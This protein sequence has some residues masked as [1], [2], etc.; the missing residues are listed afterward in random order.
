MIVDQFL[1]QSMIDEVYIITGT[2]GV[3]G[4]QN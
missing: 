2:P 1:W 4:Y 3:I